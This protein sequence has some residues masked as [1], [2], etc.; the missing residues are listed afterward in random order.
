MYMYVYIDMYIYIYT[1]IHIQTHLHVCIYTQAHTPI[2][3]TSYIYID[4]YIIHIY[5]HDHRG[6][7]DEST[8]QPTHSASGSK[9]G[10]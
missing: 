8:R 3:Y 10:Y 4:V 1:Y 9:K 6:R 7:A 5:T 2:S